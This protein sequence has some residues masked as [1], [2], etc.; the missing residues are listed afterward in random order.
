VI[1]GDVVADLGRFSDDNA[2]S[3]VDKDATPDGSTGVN[4]HTR[5][6][7]NR[8]RQQSSDEAQSDLPEA[9]GDPVTDDG[10]HAWIGK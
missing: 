8:M 7:A 6:K 3:M 2:H 9:V 1:H 5:E 4:L 10:V